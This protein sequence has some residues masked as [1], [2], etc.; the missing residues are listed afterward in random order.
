MSLLVNLRQLEKGSKRLQGDIP[1]ES[2]EV[3]S[4]DELIHTDGPLRYDIEV[5]KMERSILARGG[6]SL[7]LRC[8][9]ARCLQPFSH[10]MEIADWT[11]HAPLEG[12]ERASVTSD[13]VDLTPY[14]REDIVLG[15]PQ[16]PLCR[17]GCRGLP[18]KASGKKKASAGAGRG[19]A[20][21]SAWAELN[22]LKF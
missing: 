17:S 21:T 22:K 15:L 12:D 20:S 11:C 3:D 16:H 18:K 9:C 19:E 1:A 6:I 7:K 13:C 10:K 5:Q 4:L 2:L 8:E 14:I